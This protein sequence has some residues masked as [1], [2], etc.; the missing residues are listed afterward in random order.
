M[1]GLFESIYKND[2]YVNVQ[3][4]VVWKWETGE[5]IIRHWEI[6][7]LYFKQNVWYCIVIRNCTI[8]EKSSLIIFYWSV[9]MWN[10]VTLWFSFSNNE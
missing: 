10:E 2:E 4:C 1:F 6:N 7:A 3:W 9:F 8:F 5:F